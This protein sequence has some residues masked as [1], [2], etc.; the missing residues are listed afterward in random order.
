MILEAQIRAIYKE[1]DRKIVILKRR[2]GLRCI[3]GC[4]K[5]CY[6]SYIETSGLDLIPVVRF[7]IRKNKLEFTL[8]KLNN[9]TEN[10]PCV[11]FVPKDKKR[12]RGRCSIYKLRPTTCRLFGFANTSARDSSKVFSTCARIKKA[13]PARVRRAEELSRDCN[14]LLSFGDIS[15]KLF[16][17]DPGLASDKGHINNVIRS[18]I[19][20]FGLRGQFL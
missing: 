14:Y 12:I 13:M 3:T 15:M 16:G 20:R 7:L 9:L 8:G 1:I 2:T 5:C 6:S 11:F 17:I 4:G 10:S 19:E 18:V